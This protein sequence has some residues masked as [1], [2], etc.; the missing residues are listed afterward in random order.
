[1][2][3]VPS[4]LLQPLC[5]NTN[6]TYD[7][8]TTMFPGLDDPQQMYQ[9]ALLIATDWSDYVYHDDQCVTHDADCPCQDDSDSS[10]ESDLYSLIESADVFFTNQNLSVDD[11]TL[12]TLLDDVIAD[13]V[14]PDDIFGL[15]D[16]ADTLSDLPTSDFP[17]AET[18]APNSGLTCAVDTEEI[19]PA[20]T[21]GRGQK[22]RHCDD[23]CYPHIDKRSKMESFT[24]VLPC[25][26]NFSHG[27]KNGGMNRES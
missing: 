13:S 7:L 4:H 1:M 19:Q 6:I 18:F 10:L 2:L 21:C 24:Q 5:I 26:V 11:T 20:R 15:V 8:D 25:L 16:Y 12:L 9:P 22:R 14:I 23:I 3:D 27:S 17:Q